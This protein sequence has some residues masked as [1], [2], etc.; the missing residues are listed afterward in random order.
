[1]NKKTT[2][3][4]DP[5]TVVDVVQN[6]ATE[7]VHISTLNTRQPTEKEVT[8]SGLLA[9][10]KEQGQLTP[11]LGRPHPDKPGHI[12]LAAGAC[13]LVSCAKLGIPYRVIV[14]PMTDG[15]L[16]DA[17]LTENLQRTDPDPEAEAEL[18]QLRLDE[19]LSPGEI[20]ARYGKTELW[21]KRR[22]KILN[23]DPSV[24]KKFAPNGDL[25]HYT[26]EM[27]ERIGDLPVADQKA[28]VKD[29]W[30]ARRCTT[31]KGLCEAINRASHSLE[32][33]DW[34]N[35]PA[36]AIDGC[37]PG[38]ATDTSKSLF[39]DPKAKCGT[40]MN[41]TC[42]N[43]RRQLA[44]DL[45]FAA[46]LGDSKLSDVVVFATDYGREFTYQGK[47]IKVM[48]SWNFKETY[49]VSKKKTELIGIRRKSDTEFT[50]VFLEKIKVAGASGSCPSNVG[51]NAPKISREDALIGK[52]LAAM[53]TYLREALEIA[54]VPTTVPLM[55]LVA[56][57][58][59][60]SNNTHDVGRDASPWN[61]ITADKLPPLSIMSNKQKDT[62]ENV[63]W[64][65]VR[66]VIVQRISYQTNKDLLQKHKRNEMDKIAWLI[67]FDW[68]GEWQKTCTQDHPVPKS[69][70]TGIDPIT[71]KPVKTGAAASKPGKSVIAKATE[72]IA[73]KKAK[74]TTKNKAKAA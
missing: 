30:D 46:A 9:S 36:T 53:N 33:Q 26:T 32:G 12:E 35:D 51:N 7:F 38:C 58:G 54:P 44:I 63:I 27:K 10:I 69:W 21:V 19:G 60:N 34:V 71:L 20:A 74:K 6:V 62:E 52:R 31:L 64:E 48:S 61:H 28:F 8:A 57:F 67:G 4:T 73:K 41:G 55:R 70:G 50:R 37:G 5:D 23:I 24:R 45:A 25:A 42:F 15:E 29:S 40:C 17:I 72:A 18:I 59:T 66:K 13:R 68:E 49:K 56:L 2:T 65:A 39:P 43:K 14:K 22:L 11:G 1:M 47:T 16:K 3:T